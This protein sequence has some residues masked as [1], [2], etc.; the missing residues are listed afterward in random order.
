MTERPTTG[1]AD[2]GTP[3]HA[4]PDHGA[5]DAGPDHHR[6]PAV[7]PATARTTT[8]AGAASPAGEEGEGAPSAATTDPA[9]PAARAGVH[10]LIGEDFSLSESIGGLRGVIESI[11]PGAVFVIV[12][13]ATRE[14]TPPL[15]AS[16]A[17]AVVL[18]AA[19]LI[20]RTPVTQA[21]GGLFGVGIGVFWAWRSGEAQ[22]YFA[23]GLWTNA[24]YAVALIV[25]VLV[26]WPAVGVVVGLLRQEGTAWR[27]D[28]A[29]RPRLRRYTLAT[30]LWIT[31]FVLRLA[32]QL[33]LYL[34]AEVAWLGT[35]RLVMGVPLW[36][37]TLW[38]T[39]VLVREPAAPAAPER[40]PLP[41]R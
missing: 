29:Q 15:V 39:W 36:A 23:F 35:A 34:S 4:A 26:R 31:M 5:T 33:P 41:E 38:A 21:V 37:L 14:L 1:A 7:D 28:L 18:M 32:V 27:T 19:R 10:Q 13:V 12:F 3:D 9:A 8:A 40:Q 2:R 25:S 6:A 16:L 30:W 22:D 20:G 24:A 11:L 17:V